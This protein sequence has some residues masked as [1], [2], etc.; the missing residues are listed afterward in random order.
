[1]SVSDNESTPSTDYNV[2]FEY[3]QNALQEIQRSY[4]YHKASQASN[5]KELMVMQTLDTLSLCPKYFNKTESQ[6]YASTLLNS[7]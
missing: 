7:D 2:S 6:R 3:I 5:S 1:M 4:M